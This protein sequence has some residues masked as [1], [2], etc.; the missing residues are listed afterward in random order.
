[1]IW[2]A[3]DFGFGEAASLALPALGACIVLVWLLLLGRWQLYVARYET[4]GRHPVAILALRA[5]GLTL[6]APFVLV[7]GFSGV[8]S[9]VGWEGRDV[10]GGLLVIVCAA[11]IA[12]LGY[13][14]VRRPLF[15]GLLLLVPP[16]TLSGCCLLA[17]AI[18]ERR[19][20]DSV[21][22]VPPG[23][24]A[25]VSALR[26]VGLALL[27]P[28]VLFLGFGGVLF[29]VGWEGRD[30]ATGLVGVVCAALIVGLGY[31]AIRRPF[32]GSSLLLVP[33]LTLSGACLLAAAILERRAG[34][35]DRPGSEPVRHAALS[36]HEVPAGPH[37]RQAPLSPVHRAARPARDPRHPSRAHRQ[38]RPVS[39][40]RGDR[41]G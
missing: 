38:S 18:I 19:D 22:Y 26:T 17:A 34:D 2:C 25:R 5:V 14:A 37:G 29:L 12:G 41:G 11:L 33:P 21:R 6:L 23:R 32:L 28:F 30:V 13:V 16:L 35:H 27:A 1:M 39:P 15:G 40:R 10:A 3:I 8:L 9:L 36:A 20:P 31:L 4:P 24:H 7:L